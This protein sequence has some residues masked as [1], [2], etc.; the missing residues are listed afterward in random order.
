[1]DDVQN[2]LRYRLTIPFNQSEGMEDWKAFVI[3]KNPSAAT[4]DHDKKIYHSDSTINRVITYFYQLQFSEVTVI[5]LFAKYDTESSELNRFVANSVK[6]I[7]S[8][9]DA[10]IKQT[11]NGAREDKDLIIVAWGGYPKQANVHMKRL[12]KER[13]KLVE[14]MLAG[15]TVYYMDRMVDNKF[16]LHGMIWSYSHTPKKYERKFLPS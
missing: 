11:I 16:P 4:I 7:G 3:M 6:I 15:R 10:I 14:Q 12:Y 8:E 1:M 2:Q 5:N 13:I 9:N